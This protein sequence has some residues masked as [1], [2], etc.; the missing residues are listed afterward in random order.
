[1]WEQVSNSARA[2]KSM[3]REENRHVFSKAELV[4]HNT[5]QTSMYTR[6][7]LHVIQN[8]VAPC[9]CPRSSCF[10]ENCSLQVPT[11]P[12]ETT[13]RNTH[14]HAT[15]HPTLHEHRSP[16]R[17]SVHI[18]RCFAANLNAMHAQ[19]NVFGTVARSECTHQFMI[20]FQFLK[21]RH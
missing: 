6:R 13:Y 10:D 20:D 2:R 11:G 15:E 16:A 3:I 9:V 8:S 7:Y 4:K 12:R 1:M 17:M 21:P 14:P 19:Q 5:R 18:L